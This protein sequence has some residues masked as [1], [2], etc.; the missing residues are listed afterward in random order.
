M[1]KVSLAM[2]IVVMVFGFSTAAKAALLTFDIDFYGGDTTLAQGVLDTGTT[3]D[4]GVGDTVMVDL[5]FSITEVS[6]WKAG[7]DVQ[8]PADNLIASN[9][10]LDGW[11]P[12]PGDPQG[13]TP[14]H[15]RFRGQTSEM[16]GI[17]PGE[18]L[19]LATFELIGTKVSDNEIWLY[20]YN[21]D[22]PDWAAGINDG[23]GILDDLVVPTHLANVNV[24]PVPGALWLLGSGLAGL[25]ALRRR[26]MKN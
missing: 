24:V 26:K 2:L 18:N 11:I 15:V 19:L 4:I 12:Y 7:W 13:I 10:I 17:G 5:L 16:M 8:F 25:V 3:I 22:G 14:G 6:L 21:P 9:L 23:G 20:D 1:K